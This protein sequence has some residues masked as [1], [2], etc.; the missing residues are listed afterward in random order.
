[1]KT[2]AIFAHNAPSASGAANQVVA[3][4]DK[5]GISTIYKDSRGP[6]LGF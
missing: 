6:L 3:A 2:M 4:A 1:M 5:L